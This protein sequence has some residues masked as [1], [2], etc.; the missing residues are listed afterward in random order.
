MIVMN[1]FSD[2]SETEEEEG[3]QCSSFVEESGSRETS[4]KLDK[5]KFEMPED[6]CTEKP[7]HCESNVANVGSDRYCK[8]CKI[9]FRENKNLE[10]HKQLIHNE[11]IDAFDM[12]LEVCDLKYSCEYCKEKFFTSNSQIYHAL[13]K[14][15]SDETFCKLCF[16]SF[17]GTDLIFKCHYCDKAFYTE[18]SQK[19][20]MSKKHYQQFKR[21]SRKRSDTSS[22]SVF[23]KLCRIGFKRQVFLTKHTKK[24]HSEE[25]EAFN[26]EIKEADL[27]NK[28]RICGKKFYSKNILDHHMHRKHYKQFKQNEGR[29]EIVESDSV[30]CQLCRIGF[31]RPIF[32]SKHK[33]KVH[34]EEMNA[35]NKVIEECDLLYAC[36][37]CTKKYYSQNIL[38]HHMQR[39]HYKHHRKNENKNKGVESSSVLCQLC[40]VS[41]K[42]PIF[43]IKHKKKVHAG[44]MGAFY[45]NIEEVDLIHACR[46]CYDKFISQNT[47]DHHMK[48]K[49]DSVTRKPL[50]C[51]LCYVALKNTSDLEK[52]NTKIHKAEM[53][54]LKKDID[55]SMLLFKC[56]DCDKKFITE[57]LMC[58]HARYQ[59][60]GLQEAQ[61][62]CRLCYVDFKTSPY[63]KAHKLNIHKSQQELNAFT[64]ELK[65]ETLS[66]MCK[67]CDEWFLTENILRY[68]Y[69]YS[70]RK[71]RQDDIQCDHCNKVFKWNYGR[72]RLVEKH[73]Q[74]VHAVENFKP[75]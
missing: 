20:H 54:L 19:H 55:E 31:K 41:F 49:H 6:G 46:I 34:V 59:H 64:G 42:R 63:F 29:Y 60:K 48:R 14:H 23:C 68:H 22:A 35:F 58:Y 17:K 3:N 72:K 70:H 67:Y 37:V 8:L 50:N 43:L 4:D 24:I 40:R 15:K 73:M 39:K 69:T 12:N 10:N 36:Q 51:K 7:I 56:N 28:C 52:H 61:S 27:I 75:E 16:V 38:D 47:L 30:F 11:E 9:T 2:A 25:M 71:E 13:R 18:I 65:W 53:G 44:E 33:K 74:V 5:V 1:F 45:K 66:F 21:S 32:L 62:Y 26:K 57:K